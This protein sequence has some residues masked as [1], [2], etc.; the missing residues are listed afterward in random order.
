M[1]DAEVVVVGAGLAGLA[2]ARSLAAAGRDVVVIEAQNGVGGRVRSDVVDGYVLDRGFQVL[3]T[4]YPIL[5]RYVDLDTLDLQF[6]SPG[7]TIRQGDRFV[8]LADP[9]RE[10]SSVFSAL[11]VAT[12][13]DLV[14]LLAWRR[15]LLVGDG[16][17]LTTR[18]N[19]STADAL[20]ERG[21]SEGLIRDFFA[22][23][24]AGTFFDTDLSTSRRLTDLV[25]RCF[26]TGGVA[27]PRG[28]MQQLADAVAAPLGDRVRLGAVV[29]EVRNGIVETS[30]GPL[31]ADEVVVA[32]E[33]PVARRLLGAEEISTAERSATTC[34]YATDASPVE[35]P[36]LVLDP[37]GD[38]VTTVVPMSRVSSAYAPSGRDLLAVAGP[39]L[40]DDATAYDA[41]VR[42]L[43][44]TW[45]GSR[46]DDWD[47]LRMDRIPHAQPRMDVAD[48]VS[49]RRPVRLPSGVVV[50]G[51]HR[52]TASIQG[53]LVSGRRAAT[54]VLASLT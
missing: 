5:P 1:T 4:G 24:V 34:W 10:P 20:R 41:S 53:A 32:T 50:C 43:L 16:S 18:S 48:L 51:D 11:R 19:I 22:P 54:A 13:T 3:L 33:A 47:L 29:T 28:G 27:V 21:F 8:R 30:D 52:D 37:G 17:R 9:L 31:V 26:F 35:G 38:V 39:G 12:P 14:K 6:L 2:C 42:V 44:R 25:F 7:V 40:A 36:D 45:W 15:E 46:V 49:V 23:F